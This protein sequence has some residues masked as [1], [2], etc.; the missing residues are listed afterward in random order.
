ML[1]VTQMKRPPKVELRADVNRI[2]VVIPALAD[3]IGLEESLLLCQFVHW[4]G[5]SEHFHDGEYWTY[6]SVRELQREAFSYMSV[7]TISRKLNR[8][9]DT[10]KLLKSRDDLNK[11]AYDKTRWYTLNV[12]EMAK[13]HSISLAV[14]NTGKP[15]PVSEWY[16]LFQNETPPIQNETGVSQNETTIPDQTP[17]Q[18]PKEEVVVAHPRV[19]LPLFNAGPAFYIAKQAA[20]NAK[21]SEPPAPPE[22]AIAAEIVHLYTT[23]FGQ[24]STPLLLDQVKD[25]LV[26][27]G[28]SIIREAMGEA[29]ISKPDG[30]VSWNY[31]DKIM[32]RLKRQAEQPKANPLTHWLTF[33]KRW[34]ELTQVDLPDPATAYLTRRFKEADEALTHLGATEADVRALVDAKISEERYDYRFDYAATDIVSIITKRKAPRQSAAPGWKPIVVSPASEESMTP[35]QRAEAVRLGRLQRQQVQRTEAERRRALEGES[36]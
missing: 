27:F 15:Y 21:P 11:A 4:I 1:T 5:L 6:Q 12:P 34:H 35:E 26:E 33:K 3:E 32:Q 13:L 22:Q 29:K 25:A 14:K 2:T 36:V 23:T 20:L 17:D 16:T 31:L 28:A 19:R 18:T 30:F 24:I 8:L 7:T 10:L 9:T